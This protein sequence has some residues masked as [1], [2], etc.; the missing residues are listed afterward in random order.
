MSGSPEG[1]H[2]SATVPPASRNYTATNAS[3]GHAADTKVSVQV[4]TTTLLIMC[5]SGH[6]IQITWRDAFLQTKAKQRFIRF[7]LAAFLLAN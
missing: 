5:P 4:D 7:A 1:D 2:A 3:H 6:H